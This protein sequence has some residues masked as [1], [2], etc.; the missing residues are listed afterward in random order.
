MAQFSQYRL[1]RSCISPAEPAV[2][3]VGVGEGEHLG[4]SS[5]GRNRVG[6]ADSGMAMGRVI[7]GNTPD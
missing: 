4:G 5:R 2:L 7:C 3:C 1:R 6:F